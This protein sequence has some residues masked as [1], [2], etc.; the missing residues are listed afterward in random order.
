MQGAGRVID[1]LCMQL[2]LKFFHLMT[3][4]LAVHNLSF[5]A[6]NR[7]PGMVPAKAKYMGKDIARISQY[8]K[9]PLKIPSVKKIFF[10]MH[11]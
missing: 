4:C 10:D 3:F 11:I 6:G 7:A 9:I 8:F 5:P 2:A 1:L